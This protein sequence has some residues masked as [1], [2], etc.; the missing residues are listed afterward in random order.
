MRKCHL[1]IIFALIISVLFISSCTQLSEA[2]EK[3]KFSLSFNKNDPEAT[4]L[5]T[6]QLIESK[7]TVKLKK[8]TY[9]KVG[10]VFSGWATTSKGEAVYPDTS[11]YTMGD[12]D[13]TLFARW[14]MIRY[15][16]T[17]DKNDPEATGYTKD[18]DGVYLSIVKLTECG[19]TKAGWT[20]IGW[21]TSPTGTVEYTDK[22]D[23]QIETKDVVLYAKWKINQYTVTYNGNGNTGGTTPLSQKYDYKTIVTAA[24]NSGSLIML[25]AV[26]H[27][28]KFL[29]WNTHP[30]AKGI[31]YEAGKGTFQLTSDTV[32]YAQWDIYFLRDT[33][34]AGGLI[35]Y[36]KGDYGGGWRYLE[37]APPYGE[38]I[39]IQWGA[40][41]KYIGTQTGI[42]AGKNNTETIISWVSNKDDSVK[43]AELCN[44]FSA[45]GYSDWFLPSR[46]ELQ[47]M[48]LNLRVHGVGALA[49]PYWSSSEINSEQAWGFEMDDGVFTSGEMVNKLNV[50]LRVRAVRSF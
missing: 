47:Q 16:I 28:Y 20:F 40:Y 10:A 30:Q 33:G 27:T 24:A 38:W 13:T 32:L 14:T 17:F 23:L 8:C 1:R 15:S 45:G 26:S 41:K 36:D 25:D 5:M 12:S 18:Q 49:G 43:A 22:A 29:G 21:S 31:H 7:S 44:N 37:A 9:T 19:F 46:D 34:P 35:F 48:Y 11:N 42:G 50:S 4:G 6:E 2:E 3:E 39:N